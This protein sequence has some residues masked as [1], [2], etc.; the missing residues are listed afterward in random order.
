MVMLLVLSVC[1]SV[2]HVHALTFKSLDLET[3]FWFA[4]T[5]L[6]Y[7]GNFRVSSSGQ[8][9]GHRFKKAC[10]KIYI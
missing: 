4:G 1:L 6:E 2:C 9:Q 7:L 3:S 8:D 5:C 10:H